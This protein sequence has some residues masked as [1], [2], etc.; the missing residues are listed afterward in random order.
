V[1]SI[2]TPGGGRRKF[3]PTWI[4]NRAGTAESPITC[5]A[6]GDGE[7][8][9]TGSSLL[10][11]EKWTHVKDGIYST[12][13]AQ[14]VM[15]VFQN[16]YPLHSPGDRAKIFSVDDMNP[17]SFYVSDKTLYVWLEGGADP[18]Q[19]TM[20]A[21]PGHVVSL[22]DWPSNKL[23]RINCGKR[24]PKVPGRPSWPIETRPPLPAEMRVEAKRP[25]CRPCVVAGCT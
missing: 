13:I 25:F 3:R 8:R 18:E 4:V 16:A 7:V 15:A 20:R 21:A 9:I 17:N 22:Y 2:V 12:P 24:R 6:F 14:A 11:P 23:N 10:P 1:G 19:A 5:Q